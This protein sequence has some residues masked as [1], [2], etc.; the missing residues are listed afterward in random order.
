MSLQSKVQLSSTNPATGAVIASYDG[1]SAEQIEVALRRAR[2]AFDDWRLTSLNDR[3][4]VLR[5]SAEVL[6]RSK[7]DLAS[8]ITLEM[9]KPISEAEAEIEKCAWN[10]EYF[11]ENAAA[12]LAPEAV[13]TG[14]TR[15]YVRF[16]PLGTILAIMPW[17]FP[18]WQVFRFAAPALVAGNV[19][20]LKH[21]S[22]VPGS[23]LAIE[24]V[25]R[26]AGLPD[27]VFQ[28]LLISGA[29]AEE[30]IGDERVAC[31]TLTG[32]EATGARVAAAAGRA[33]K[34]CVLE[35][36]GSDPFIVLPDADLEAAAA[37]GVRARN[38]N[39][40]QS[41]IAAKRFIVVREVAGHFTDLLAERVKALTVGD[42]MDPE[43]QLGPL[44]RE[45]LRADLDD[46]VQRS[47]RAGAEVVT[48]GSP[49][50]GPGYFY[51]AT[52]LGKVSPEMA[53]A[54]EETFGPV[55][56]VI[57]A[58][59]ME[60]ATAIANGSRY[61]LGASLWTRDLA[62]AERLAPRIEAGAV[63]INSMTASDPRLPFGGVKRSGYGRELSRHGLL[64]FVN[65]KTVSIA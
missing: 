30:L 37:I 43:T 38:Q 65:I 57:E 53:A 63:F 42:P 11:A 48:G 27:G 64:E 12:F 59:D 2:D 9:G 39:N 50:D 51:Q 21:A 5:Q 32:S 54:C 29:A 36:G 47:V 15:S 60:E 56:A 26:N 58:R 1:A 18:L 22:N 34:K 19:T 17:N 33:I 41:C 40:G 62:L 49:I 6:R 24:E 8:T 14:V 3:M 10:C 16:D 7:P 46:Q 61:G 45:D 23:S 52:V 55:A 25:L 35:L 4:Q 31:V 28:S 44:A 13:E 20:L